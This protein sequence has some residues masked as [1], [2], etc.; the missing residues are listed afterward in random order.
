MKCITVQY[1]ET[2]FFLHSVCAAMRHCHF[3]GRRHV[4][5]EVGQPPRIARR[6]PA[7]VHRVRAVHHPRLRHLPDCILRMLRRHQRVQLHDLHGMISMHFLIT[8]AHLTSLLQ[9]T[10]RT[11]TQYS[12]I[13]LLLLIAQIVFGV[14]LFMNQDEVKKTF[15]KVLEKMWQ[16]RDHQMAFWDGVQSNVCVAALLCLSLTHSIEVTNDRAFRFVS[17]CQQ[18]K[19]CGLTSSLDWLK[20]QTPKSCCEADV[21]IC[22]PVQAY[23]RGCKSAIE[24]LTYHTNTLAYFIL[25]VAG[26]EVGLCDSLAGTDD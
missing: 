2:P 19:C 17:V 10:T 4:L 18:L 21:T 20:I 3:G 15:G 11:H 13:L 24:D 12:T 16:E 8:K 22:N 26:I 23:T 6:L 5:P 9:Y 1:F 7:A 14:M 25:A